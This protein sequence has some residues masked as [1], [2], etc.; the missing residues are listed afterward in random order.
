MPNIK[1][2]LQRIASMDYSRMFKTIDDMHARTGKSKVKLF[3]DVVYCGLKYR[4]G[5]NDYKL[6]EFYDLTR[7]QRETY[8]T[9]GI[10]N[11]I[12]KM[13]NNKQYIDIFANKLLFNEKFEKYLNRKWLNLHKAS[14]ED[15]EKFMSDMDIVITKPEDGTC[16]KGVE[17]LYKKDFE[18]VRALY[19]HIIASGNMLA[20]EC[21]VQHPDVARLYPLSINTYRI[22][23]VLVDG[24]AHVVYAFIRIGNHGRFVDNFNSGGMS[25]PVD[26][27]TGII[28]HPGYDKD[29]MTYETHPMTGTKI[30]G[31][32][33]PCW[34]E[35]CDMCLE[36]A[37]IVPEVG[38]IA[39]D[40]AISDKGP[41]FV[42]GNDFPGHDILQ[43]PPHV[44]DKI[45]MLPEFKKYIKNL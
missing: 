19:H 4:A 17:K 15:F 36:A 27:D 18:N 9:R 6:C 33:L 21:I 10:N 35:A 37:K 41:V 8:V 5:Y 16:G 30:V 11:K 12:V 22:V 34:K 38:Y 13:L 45:G 39:W 23:T 3:A 28:T 40:V 26:V 31:Y 29:Q 42:E 20:E 1:Y 2:M 24:T 43:M 7:K 44:P 32:Q 25:A 14:F